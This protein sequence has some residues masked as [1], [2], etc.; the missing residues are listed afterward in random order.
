[1][2]YKHI[3]KTYVTSAPKYLGIVSKAWQI[4]FPLVAFLSLNILGQH[5]AQFNI[6]KKKK[7]AFEEDAL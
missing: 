7:K 3:H 2:T 5:S 1:M 6:C 4:Y